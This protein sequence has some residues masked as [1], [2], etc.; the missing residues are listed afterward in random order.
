MDILSGCS[1]YQYELKSDATVLQSLA[2]TLVELLQNNASKIPEEKILAA[3][4]AFSHETTFRAAFCAANGLGCI[5]REMKKGEINR[6]YQ[7]SQ[8]NGDKVSNRFARDCIEKISANDASIQYW[9]SN[10]LG[11]KDVTH[12]YFYDFGRNDT[13]FTIEELRR[14]PSSSDQLETITNNITRTTLDE[15]NIRWVGN[16]PQSFYS[17]LALRV[18]EHFGGKQEHATYDQNA[19]LPAV[20]HLRHQLSSNVMPLM[21][22]NRGSTRHRAMAFKCL[23]DTVT[24]ENGP[25]CSLVRGRFMGQSHCWNIVRIEGSEFVV[26]LIHEPGKFYALSSPEATKYKRD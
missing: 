8:N 3:V 9:I 24:E 17:S 12:S 11:Y 15:W 22:L 18:C 16:T 5:T 13:F 14:I 1:L 23:C 25:E 4:A 19:H 2:S 7:L 20:N 26:D 10:S 21:T 6:L